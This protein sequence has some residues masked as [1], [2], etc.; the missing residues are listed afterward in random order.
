MKKNYSALIAVFLLVAASPF[1]L[2]AEKP[3]QA[4]KDAT[5][6]AETDTAAQPR[7]RLREDLNIPLLGPGE[8]LTKRTSVSPAAFTWKR[9]TGEG[10]AAGEAAV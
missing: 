9:I 8:T 3:E 1:L 4:A 10:P 5:I 7:F 6:Q 2:A